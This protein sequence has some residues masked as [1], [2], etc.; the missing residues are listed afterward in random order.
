MRLHKNADTP[1]RRSKAI[2]I[3]AQPA[4]ALQ[5]LWEFRN[6]QRP[7]AE[8]QQP[9][10]P[11]HN[12]PERAT[13]AGRGLIIQPSG[14]EVGKLRPKVMLQVHFSSRHRLRHQSAAGHRPGQ[15]R[16]GRQLRDPTQDPR[17]DVPAH[18]S[19]LLPL[20]HHHRA[21]RTRPHQGLP[22]ASTR[23]ATTPNRNPRSRPADPLRTPSEDSWPMAGATTRTRS[24]DL[25]ITP[26]RALPGHQHRHPRSR[27]RSLR[28]SDLACLCTRQ[29]AD[30]DDQALTAELP[31]LA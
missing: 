31:S 24:L 19:Q 15:Q 25:A 14:V 5:L 18:A 22:S 10:E 3:L 1:V 17:S 11:I 2:W 16:P 9:G 29:T 13:S 6:Q 27:Q 4:Q 30:P 23:R 20:R 26:P 21:P 12:E 7:V 28:T 8:P